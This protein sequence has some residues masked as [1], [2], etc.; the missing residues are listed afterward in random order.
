MSKKRSIPTSLFASPDFF[1][2]SSDTVRV[3]MLG[4]I[5]DVDDEGRGYAHARLLARKLDKCP[6]DIEAALVELAAHGI[7]RCYLVADRR[8]YVLCHWHKYQILSKP[9]P[10]AYPPPPAEE[11]TPTT[12]AQDHPA[13]PRKPP[14]T[15]G[16]S[17]PESEEERE[18]ESERKR[19]E[20]DAEREVP[21]GTAH[22]PPPRGSSASSV[23]LSLEHHRE[24]AY[25]V[26][27][28]LQIPLTTELAAV[29]A[30]FAETSPFSLIGE[31]IEARSWINDPRRNRAGQQMTPAFFRRWLRRAQDHA[32]PGQD[33]EQNRQRGERPRLATASSVGHA[34]HATNQP[35]DD[36]YQAS[37]L[38]RL[39]EVKAQTAQKQ[40]VVA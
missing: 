6:Q 28:S 1:E 20:D 23:A 3:I 27:R 40:E 10:S 21:P 25:Q 35:A 5:L 11:L 39:A 19:K 36:P 14:E 12:A 15:P 9:T 17:L 29:V 30:E 24:G 13:L 8:Y 37:F 4:L 32:A 34:R 16:E 26:A 18:K 33:D 31:A 22:L 2:L 38:R 7:V